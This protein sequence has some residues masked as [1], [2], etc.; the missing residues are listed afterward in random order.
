MGSYAV[1]FVCLFLYSVGIDRSRT[2]AMEFNAVQF[3]GDG[4]AA[5]LHRR[6]YVHQV[7]DLSHSVQHILATN[8]KSDNKI[9]TSRE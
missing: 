6:R 9:I 5:N 3:I 8:L 2:K 7:V 4:I 1:Q